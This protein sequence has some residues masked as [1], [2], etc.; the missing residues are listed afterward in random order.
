V[1]EKCQSTT[2]SQVPIAL[3]S[4]HQRSEKRLRIRNTSAT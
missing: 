4:Q 2:N 3:N 1:K